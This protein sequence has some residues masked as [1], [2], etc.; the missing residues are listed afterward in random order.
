MVG[1]RSI[2]LRI[3]S[4]VTVMIIV[5]CAALGRSGWWSLWEQW[6]LTNAEE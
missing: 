4:N 3:T 6:L 5:M 1:I 2:T